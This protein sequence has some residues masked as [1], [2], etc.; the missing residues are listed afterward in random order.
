MRHTNPRYHLHSV[1][2]E[3]ETQ[4]EK[5]TSQ[6][7]QL[8]RGKDSLQTRVGGMAPAAVLSYCIISAS[9]GFR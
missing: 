1:Y 5:G 9:A 7:T 6:I 4:R 3:T 8:V 2:E